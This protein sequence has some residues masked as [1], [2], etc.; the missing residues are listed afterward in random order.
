LRTTLSMG[1]LKV[2]AV[3]VDRGAY[4]RFRHFR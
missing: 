4:D 3:G 1:V 2:R